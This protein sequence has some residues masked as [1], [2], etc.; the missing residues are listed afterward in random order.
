MAARI[1]RRPLLATAAG[2]A[3]WPASGRSQ[4]A[5]PRRLRIGVLT[6]LSGPYART[7][8]RGSILAAEMAAEDYKAAN[9]GFVIEIVGGDCASQP[10]RAV[11]VAQSWL[12]RD[13]VSMIIDVPG[14]DAAT[15][16][17]ELVRARDRVA[18]FSGAGSTRLTGRLCSPNHVHWTYDTWSLAHGTGRALV[19]AGGTTWFFITADYQFG[20]QLQEETTSFVHAAG[21]EVLGS[22]P[23]P[24][25]GEDFADAVIQSVASG[26][27]VIGLANA[28]DDTVRCLRQAASFGVTAAGRQIAALLFQLADVHAVGLDAARGLVTTEAFYWDR[29][30]ASRAFADRFSAR[31]GAVKPGMDQAGVYAATL[32]YLRAAASLGVDAAKSSGRAVVER[33]KAIPTDDPLFGRGSIRADGRKLHDMYLFQVKTPM[34]ARS[35][36]DLYQLRATIPAGQA[37]RPIGE[38]GCPLIPA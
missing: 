4:P 17:A 16:V 18:V 13:D 14:S 19:E 15:R 3:L 23:M 21:G 12:D 30:D 24:F 32:H 36:W 1:A 27:K 26:A 31:S 38:G 37:F 8:G 20:H 2:F 9:P 34:E 10:D 5:P 7:T 25:P 6:D 35:E 33:M 22:Y 29:D 11:S 28:G